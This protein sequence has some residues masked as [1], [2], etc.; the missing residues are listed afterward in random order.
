ML[1]LQI[2]NKPKP[3]LHLLNQAIANW[4]NL[5]WEC[6]FD[7][8]PESLYFMATGKSKIESTSVAF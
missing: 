7:I 6:G 3:A 1:H 2:Q 4:E 5:A 8:A